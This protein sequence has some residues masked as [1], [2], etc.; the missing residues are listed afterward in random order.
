[1]GSL[2]RQT[3]A[4]P[5]EGKARIITKAVRYELPAASRGRELAPCLTVIN[6]ACKRGL[7]TGTMFPGMKILHSW[8]SDMKTCI[9]TGATSG[10][11]HSIATGLATLQHTVIMLGR[12]P[13]KGATLAEQLKSVTGNRNIHYLNVD[14]CSQ[15]Q[16]RA[17]GNK[18]RHE[19][20]VIDVLINNAAQWNSM[21]E[22]TEDGIEKQFAV[23]HLAY[24]LL[25]HLLYPHI[26]NSNDARIINIG[27]DSHRYGR[28]N[29]E[30]LNLKNEYHGLKAY[31]QSKL[32]NLLFSYHLH[33]IK[34]E[35]EISVYCVQPGLVKTDIGIK[36]TSLLHSLAWKLRRLTGVSCEKAASHIIYL[37]TSN[38]VV[39]RSG[40]Y[41]ENRKPKP[42]SFPSQRYK[43]AEK[44]WEMSEA[45]CGIKSYFQ[46]TAKENISSE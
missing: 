33:R 12:N 35:K 18:I 26:R 38:D 23:N 37:A 29:F 14:L 43:D 30:N 32:A 8:L 22:L 13:E 5:E 17:V 41:W 20:P 16:I 7:S 6:F 31:G 21:Y 10:I 19:F 44:L 28:I 34:P 39:G 11:G 2:P 24:F 42:S 25:T 4:A 46:D 45:L 40:L 15:K 3:K 9:V 1:V 36:H 27:S